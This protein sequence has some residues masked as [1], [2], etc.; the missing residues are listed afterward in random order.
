MKTKAMI[1]MTAGLLAGATL[2]S[3]AGDWTQFRGAERTGVS[4]ETGWNAQWKETAPKTLWTWNGGESYACTLV[5]GD[6]V[7]VTGS[8]AKTD[9]IFCLNADTGKE[10]WKTTFPHSKRVYVPDSH[11]N[12]LLSTPLL[13][14][15]K[16]Y[17]VLREGEFHCLSVKDG[18]SAWHLNLT[19]ATGAKPTPFGIA[20]SPILEGNLLLFNLGKS[21]AAIDASTGKV[22]WKSVGDSGYASPV[23]YTRNGKRETALFGASDVSGTEVKTGKEL[24]RIP[25]KVGT[26]SAPSGDPIFAENKLLVFSAD[27]ARQMTLDSTAPATAWQTKNLCS[28]FTNAILL[29]GFLY[30][31]NRNKL[32]CVDW[33]TGATRWEEKGLGQG[34]LIAADG[35][36]I[37]LTERGDLLSVEATPEK[38]TELGRLK[39]FDGKDVFSSAGYVAPT[40]ANGKLYCRHAGGKLICLDLRAK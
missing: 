33:K 12:A 38:Y 15:G 34:A 24:W 4:S 13:H 19:Q 27:T 28:D 39:L 18:K 7:Y 35:K 5:S 40:L 2:I 31:S 30:G 10:I 36:L 1:L 25:W 32:A 11:A 21:G 23:V 22:V 8:D 14:G 20:T 9:S 37:V 3:S 6:R 17:V 29:N 16:L 26:F